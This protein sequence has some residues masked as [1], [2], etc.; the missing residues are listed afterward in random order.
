MYT[1]YVGKMDTTKSGMLQECGSYDNLR[2][3]L[4]GYEEQV[5]FEKK[6]INDWSLADG[7]VV[8][9]GLYEVNNGKDNLLRYEHIR[10]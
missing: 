8:Y 5:M 10:G 9:V 6:G 7:E 3:A 1:I 2:H 4:E